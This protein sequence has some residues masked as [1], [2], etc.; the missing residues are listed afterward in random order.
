MRRDE[1]LIS[2]IELVQSLV[3]SAVMTTVTVHQAKTHFSRLIERALAG[4]EI[5][6]MRGHEPMVAL[7]PVRTTKAKRRLGGLRGLIHQMADDFD[8][9]LA[10]FAEHSA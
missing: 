8:A 9:P 5:V 10:D 4:E 6:V 3:H 1:N 2:D 7:T